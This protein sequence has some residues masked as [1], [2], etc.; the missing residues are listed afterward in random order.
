[1]I[2]TSAT[3]PKRKKRL[4]HILKMKMKILLTYKAARSCGQENLVLTY[5]DHEKRMQTLNLKLNA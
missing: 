5:D 1:M 4:I 3:S 2:A